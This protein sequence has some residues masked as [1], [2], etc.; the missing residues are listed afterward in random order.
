MSIP[1]VITA[2]TPHYVIPAK[3]G[4]QLFYQFIIQVLHID[5]IHI[6][7]SLDSSLRWNDSYYI[8]P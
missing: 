7:E 2:N 4:I 3:A 1:H 5:V 6:C 8:R